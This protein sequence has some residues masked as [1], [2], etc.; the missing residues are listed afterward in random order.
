MLTQESL[1]EQKDSHLLSSVNTMTSF[2]IYN[3]LLDQSIFN[4]G[5]FLF[6]KWHC[7]WCH[8]NINR[9]RM[10]LS[11]PRQP[12]DSVKTGVLIPQMVFPSVVG[13]TTCLPFCCE[14][15]QYS[16]QKRRTPDSSTETKNVELQ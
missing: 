14:A 12:K 1:R 15:C 11:K 16:K 3:S 7:R 13:T 6:L 8:C 10:I 4:R 5:N 2:G 9:V